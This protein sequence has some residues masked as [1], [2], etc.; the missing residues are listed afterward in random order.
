MYVGLYCT[1]AYPCEDEVLA[2]YRRLGGRGIGEYRNSTGWGG[3]ST[4]GAESCGGGDRSAAV[5]AF[6]LSPRWLPSAAGNA[7]RGDYD[8]KDSSL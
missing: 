8:V 3:E 2:D 4:M 1:G 7:W 6:H 5:S